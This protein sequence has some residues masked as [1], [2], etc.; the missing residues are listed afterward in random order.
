MTWLDRLRALL[1][2]LPPL[3]RRWIGDPGERER[4]ERRVRK[5]LSKK[6]RKPRR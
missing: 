4:H 1:R 2:R 6:S 5:R 3:E